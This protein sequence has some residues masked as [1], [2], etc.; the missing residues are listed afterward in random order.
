MEEYAIRWLY[1]NIPVDFWRQF[2]D[3]LNT[4]D[5]ERREEMERINEQL[6]LSAKQASATHLSYAG[7]V[8][9]PTKVCRTH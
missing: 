1:V 6:G 2:K 4:I 7:A 3:V 8:R 5:L 9:V